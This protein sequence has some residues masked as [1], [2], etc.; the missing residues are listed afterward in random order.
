MQAGGESKR[1]FEEGG[2]GKKGLNFEGVSMRIA[3]Q[4]TK[5]LPGPR[6]LNSM[7]KKIK[8]LYLHV[9]YIEMTSGAKGAQHKTKILNTFF[10]A[11]LPKD[12]CH[13]ARVNNDR[14]EDED[15]EREELCMHFMKVHTETE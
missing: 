15:V 2:D 8:M 3:S 13:L 14:N 1:I 12:K 5:L 9:H 7:W 10:T 6:W 11:W 4:S